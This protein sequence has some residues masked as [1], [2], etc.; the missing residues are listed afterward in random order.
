MDKILRTLICDGQISLSVLEATSLVQRAVEIHKTTPEASAILGGLLTCGAYIASSLK[1]ERGSVSLT[2]KAKDGDGAVSVSA[3]ADLHVRGYADGTCS[4]TLK[5]GA[6][7]VVRE[8]GFSTRPF[9]GT[10]E[11]LSDD[12]SDI[13]ETYFGQS[14]QI[15]TA[16]ALSTEFDKNGKCVWAGGVVMQLLPDAQQE[17]IELAGDAFNTY[18]AG[19]AEKFSNAENIY[20]EYFKQLANDEVTALFP[21]YRCNCS[22]EK[23]RGVL[24][25]V[26]KAELLKICEELG[27]V[28]VHCHYC[29]KDYIYD[30]KRVEEIF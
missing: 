29:N 14:E 13:L 2:V 5:G 6:L 19:A 28:K 24:A 18:K 11:I 20:N 17:Q 15:P 21:E 12:I 3:D 7:T 4:H 16:V 8:D 10:C 25:S 9:V 27:E 23:I 1:S 30:K 22:E 26:G